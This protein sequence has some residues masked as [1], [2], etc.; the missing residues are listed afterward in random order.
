M[1][2]LLNDTEQ[3]HFI[4]RSLLEGNTPHETFSELLNGQ[5]RL[6]MPEHFGEMLKDSFESRTRSQYMYSQHT[7]QAHLTSNFYDMDWGTSGF[8]ALLRSQAYPER[9]NTVCDAGSGHTK[10]Q[11]VGCEKW[12]TIGILTRDLSAHQFLLQT[13]GNGLRSTLYNCLS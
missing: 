2:N 8:V 13:P 1:V 12:L 4:N 7:L 9:L 3:Q 10:Y 11:Y 5:V 6:Q